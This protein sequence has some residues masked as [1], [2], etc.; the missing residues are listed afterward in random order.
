MS[1]QVDKTTSDEGQSQLIDQ[2]LSEGNEII[3]VER[4]EEPEERQKVVNAGDYISE[5]FLSVLEEHRK[6]CEKEGKF[7][8]AE[9]A[10]KRLKELRKYEDIKKK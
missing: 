8:E 5:D 7:H 9:A 4:T 1:Q 10:R 3:N 2:T 6:I